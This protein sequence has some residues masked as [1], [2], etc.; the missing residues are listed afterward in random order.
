MIQVAGAL[1]TPLVG[2]YGP[3]P[4]EVRMKYFKNAI[5]LDPSAVCTPCFKHDFR[6]CIK[7]FPSP[8]F[9][10]IT[11]EDVLQAVDYL[12]FKFTGQHFKYVAPLLKEP[13]LSGIEQYMLSA[14]KGLAFFPRY[15][16]HPNCISV[17]PNPFTKADVTDLSQSFTRESYPFVIYFNEIQPKYISLYNNSKGMVRPGGHFIVYKES[18]A[19]EALFNDVKMD[20]G[21]SFIL[22]LTKFVPET[23]TF[24]IVGKKAY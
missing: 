17:D 19:P 5:G 6:G 3:F 23:G 22:L 12:K 7:G 16:R 24:I 21:K 4:S 18:G 20:V 9:T 15:Y 11:V 14:D 2:L 1:G 10:L 8:C 13:D